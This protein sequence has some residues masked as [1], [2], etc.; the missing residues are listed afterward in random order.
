ML[1]AKYCAALVSA[2]LL[3]C[4]A[5][6]KKPA[7]PPP[8]EAPKPVA[9]LV[10][11][12][13]G[14]TVAGVIHAKGT[15]DL[16][17]PI[18]M[19]QDPACNL[20]GTEPNSSEEELVK[21]GGLAN[22]YIYIKSGLGNIHYPVP[23]TPVVLDQKGCRYVPHVLALMVGQSLLVKNSDMTM[24]NVHATPSA[25][26]NHNSDITE[27][28]GSKPVETSFLDPEVMIPFRCNNHPWMEAYVNV[29]ANPFYTISDATGHYEIRGLP[30]G[31]YTL[32]AV[33]EHIEEQTT[34]ITVTA[35]G[36][37]TADFTLKKH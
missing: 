27:A 20:P 36:T 7:P 34:T 15:F 35:H 8:V 29:A 13:N 28:A 3:L 24:H 19:G 1:N 30:P 25:P 18:D 2:S 10:D 11:Y 6:C 4:T 12:A 37:T 17:I 33:H 23:T 22:V 26:N 14:G 9:P 31:T 21:D 16:S 32:A 5:G